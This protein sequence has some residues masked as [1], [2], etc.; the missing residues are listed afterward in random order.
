MSKFKTSGIVINI[1]DTETISS[2]DG[3]K[4]WEKMT[5]V[6]DNKEKYNNF[7]IIEIFGDQPVQRF[8]ET[9]SLGDYVNCEVISSANRY[10]K[11]GVEKFFPKI[12]F[13]DFST[14]DSTPDSNTVISS[15]TV[16]E[17][18]SKPIV[19]ESNVESDDLPF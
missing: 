7:Q 19:S 15:N 8:K 18:V 3:A 9:V 5:F 10:E 14:P 17:S 6:I 13:I 4:S 2:K 12:S 16:S 11:D 1:S